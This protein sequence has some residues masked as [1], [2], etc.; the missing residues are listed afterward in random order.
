[1]EMNVWQLLDPEYRV[2]VQ[3][4]ISR[5][6][7]AQTQTG[8]AVEL[9]TKYGWKL[10]LEINTHPIYHDGQAIEIQAIAT[11][12]VELVSDRPF[13]SQSLDAQSQPSPPLEEHGDLLLHASEAANSFLLEDILPKSGRTLFSL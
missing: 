9:I 13:N 7:D 1:M 5:T 11:T 4:M 8:D 12:P 6:L 2:V 10:S 3:K